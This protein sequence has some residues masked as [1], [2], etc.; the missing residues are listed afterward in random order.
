MSQGGR[1]MALALAVLTE[2]VLRR[3]VRRRMVRRALAWPGL[4][5]AGALLLAVVFSAWMLAPNHVAVQDP[6]LAQALAAQGLTPRTDDPDPQTAVA[7]QRVPRAAYRDPVTGAL[8]LEVD[9]WRTLVGGVPDNLRAEAALREA[10]GAGWRLEPVAPPAR[11]ADLTLSVRWLAGLN[12]VLFVLYGAVIGLGGI[13]TDRAEGVLEAEL[14]LP[15]PTWLH[16]VARLLAAGLLL[17]AALAGTLATVDA[18]I[19]LEDW[20]RW[21]LQGSAAA[22]AAAGLGLAADPGGLGGTGGLSGPLSRALTACTG[23]LALGAA[24]PAVG[25]WLPIAAVGALGVGQ[26]PALTALPLSLLPVGLGVWRFQ[27]GLRR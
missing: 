26:A 1:G 9:L 2:T 3:L 19:G 27:R 14:A 16:A 21:G 10:E 13:T 7:A 22:L 23:L 6:P 17:S 24:W 18:L 20:A 4:L 15:V 25:A 11:S 12:A 8:I 5:T